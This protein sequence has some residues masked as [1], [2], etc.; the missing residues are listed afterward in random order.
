MP[1]KTLNDPGDAIRLS[2]K[3][4]ALFIRSSLNERLKLL[5]QL[6][7]YGL[8]NARLEEIYRTLRLV[9]INSRFIE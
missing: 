7:H 5:I 8:I 6:S 1:T 9:S 2:F 3:G 4:P